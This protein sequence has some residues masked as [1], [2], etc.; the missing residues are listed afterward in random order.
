MEKAF[1]NVDWNTL[2]QILKV[3]GVKYR[4][5]RVIF[6][7]YKNQTAVIRVD[8]QERVAEVGNGVRQGCSLFPMLFNLYIEQAVKECKEKFGEDIKVQGE[9]MKSLWCADDIIILS[10]TAKVL[11]GDQIKR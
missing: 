6:N 4:E 1:D 9:E 5:Q 2:F 11:E 8:G 3:A 10:E 7:L